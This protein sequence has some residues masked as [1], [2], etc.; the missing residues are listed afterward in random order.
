MLH[1]RLKKDTKADRFLNRQLTTRY[2]TYQQIFAMLLPLILDQ[3]FISIISLLT[4]AM[5]SSSSQESVS[6]VSLVTPVYQMIYAIYS[7]ISSAGTVI[8]AQYKGH[9]DEEKMKKAAGQI[10][11]FTFCTAVVFSTIL[12]IFAGPLVRVMFAG[13]DELI[14]AKAT[15]YLIGCALSFIS[16]SLYLGGFAVFRGVGETKICLRLSM[17]INLLHLFASFVFIN[18][19]NLDII[20]T[21]LSL[22]LARLVGGVMAI[23]FLLY[24]K[25]PLRIRMRDLFSF[26]W[27]ILKTVIH[28]SLPFALEQVCFNGG[29]IIVSMF[30]VKL[31]TSN[32]A[33]NAVSNSTLYVFYAMGQAV[34]NLCVTIV[35]QCIGADDKDMAKRY[36]KKMVWLG[37]ACILVAL[38]VLLPF[39]NPIL[40]LFQA[41]ENTLGQIYILLAIAFVPMALFWSTSNVL[42]NVLRAAGDVNFTSYVSLATMW[43]FR[44]GLSYVVSIRMHVGING[45]WICMGLEWLVR[46]IIFLLRFRSGKWLKQKTIVETSDST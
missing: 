6:A 46:S 25:S 16:L 2:F 15:D 28:T 29:G 30:I 22:N 37:E 12:V 24:K 7:A 21:A 20:G 31:G 40:C 13:A 42:P 43:V 19:M 35:G 38:A 44:V 45:V 18:L 36:G 23:Y 32:V 41:P 1:M 34:V 26:H 10:I 39:L 14:I 17:I 9:G 27:D 11:S 33:A 5:V 8:I 3:F 4:S